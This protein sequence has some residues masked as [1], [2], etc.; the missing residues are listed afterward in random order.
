VTSLD[1]TSTRSAPTAGA[2]ASFGRGPRARLLLVGLLG[3]LLFAPPVGTAQE[4]EETA[5][6]EVAQRKPK[7]RKKATPRPTLQ[8]EKFVVQKEKQVED[9]RQKVIDRLEAIIGRTP[10]TSPD[11]PEYLFRKALLLEERARFYFNRA[12]RRDDTLPSNEAEKTEQERLK[13]QDLALSRQ[14]RLAA[15]KVWAQI[16]KEYPTFPNA[17]QACFNLAQNLSRMGEGK[18]ALRY[19]TDLIKRFPNS[20]LLPDTF[21][22]IGEYYFD[23]DDMATALKAYQRV[24]FF[25]ESPLYGFG[26]YKQ[27]WCYYNLGDYKNAMKRFIE[28]I[29]FSERAQGDRKK[30]DLYNESRRELILA[31]SHAATAE[32]AKEFFTGVPLQEGAEYWKWVE[33]RLAD[34]Y[35]EQGK[36]QDAIYLYKDLISQNPGSALAVTLQ[37]KVVRAQIAVGG[38][39]D[40]SREVFELIRQ[41]KAIQS[42]TD[43]ERSEARTQV[44]K[45]VRELAIT[46]H[47]DATKLKSQ[48][49][50]ALAADLYK[51]YQEAFGDMPEHGYEMKFFLGELLYTLKRWDQ[52]ALQYL[53]VAKADPRGKYVEKAIFAAIVSFNKMLKTETLAGGE[54]TLKREGKVPDPLPLPEILQRMVEACE[55]YLATVPP[56]RATNAPDVAYRL[57]RIY[58]EHYHFKEAATRFEYFLNR[59]PTH[60]LAI[61]AGHALLDCLNVLAD[62]QRLAEWGK[63]LAQTDVARDKTA[64]KTELEDITQG[65]VLK[66]IEKLT[67]EGKH[68]EAAAA[69]EDFLARYPKSPYLDK[70]LNNAATAM[71]KIAQPERAIELRE[72]LVKEVPDSPLAA[73]AM[74]FIGRTYHHQGIY[75]LAAAYYEGLAQ[76]HPTYPDADKALYAAALFR[77]GGGEW[78]KAIA[79]LN[80]YLKKYGKDRKGADVAEKYFRI[81]TLYQKQGNWQRVRAHFQRFLANFPATPD[82]RLQALW[83]IAW[84]SFKLMSRPDDKK[85]WKLFEKVIE[86]YNALGPEERKKLGKG[87]EAVAQARFQQAEV[88]FR[89][90]EKM[91]LSDPR[92]IKKQLSEKAKALLE[93]GNAFYDVIRFMQAEWAI[94]AYARTGQIFQAFAKAL[95]DSPPPKRLPAK[96]A[97][98]YK[99]QIE[100]KALLIEKKAREAY[101]KCLETSRELKVYTEWTKVAENQ[102]A[103]LLPKEYAEANEIKVQPSFPVDPNPAQGKNPSEVME[104]YRTVLKNDVANVEALNNLGILLRRAGDWQAAV[105]H[106]RRALTVDPKNVDAY[107][108]LAWTYYTV[109]KFDLAHL[110]SL[111]AER[112]IGKPDAGILN[113]WGLI[114]LK[115]QEVARAVASFKRAIE[116]NAEFVPARLNFAAIALNYSDYATAEREF[117]EALRI[118]SRLAL[119]EVGLGLALR[120]S[121]RY[122]EAQA[123]YE[124]ALQLENNNPAAHFNLGILY[125]EFLDK[126]QDALASFQRFLEHSREVDPR[127]QREAETRI[128]NLKQFLDV[129]SKQGKT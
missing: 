34:L 124:R 26:L 120:G 1:T 35:F 6:P 46:Y 74:Y 73:E 87:R 38:R 23:T 110:V 29:R 65:A 61:Y 56:E 125:Q 67:A 20:K 119:A 11:Y 96:L 108:N 12:M 72:R 82:Q 75:S 68:Q 98:L 71:T 66:N 7:K 91:R 127:Y 78:D 114:Y 39:V 28:V 54:Q 52:A 111:N 25:T 22:A 105:S 116:A 101:I 85:L 70:V 123:E 79:N 37:T 64:F 95:V 50:Y 58:Y 57:A 21:L 86:A 36:H 60:R 117:R 49:V 24:T 47:R 83:Q 89:K 9:A 69:Y 129:L 55:L 118:D 59:F 10:T 8:L 18:E 13:Q 53:A 45:M 115:R 3:G 100:E 15:L 113:N 103:V 63:K 102:L 94:A 109:G 99:E 92:K 51:A 16:Y 17:D 128:K 106:F 32:R 48:E 44:E 126:P 107:R 88:L 31:Y 104:A 121:R 76:I 62:Y 30:L 90:F 42:G 41:Y 93:A 80:A 2:S 27:A 40:V 5:L 14:A 33:P 19:Y 81:G 4:K 97:Q 43:A 84:A 112:M 77:E 122:S